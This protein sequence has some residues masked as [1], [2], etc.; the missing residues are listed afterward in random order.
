MLHEANM[1]D[2]V[3]I[4]EKEA[5]GGNNALAELTYVED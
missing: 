2:T 1:K 3:A 4:L 5:Q